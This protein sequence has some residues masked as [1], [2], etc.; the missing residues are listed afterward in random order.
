M[1]RATQPSTADLKRD[2]DAL[3]ADLGN[4]TKELRAFAQAQERSLSQR[5]TETAQAAANG[6]VG[7]AQAAANGFLGATEGL[8][9]TGAQ[10]AQNLRS[11]AEQATSGAEELVREHPAGTVAGA[12]AI[13][14]LVG[15]LAARR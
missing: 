8:R 10:Q 12:A 11:L 9:E 2:F 13:G 15:A 1:A 4:L 5:A 14:F 6:V 7:T 3:K